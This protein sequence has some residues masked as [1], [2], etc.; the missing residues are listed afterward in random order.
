MSSFRFYPFASMKRI[1]FRTSRIRSKIKTLRS[2]LRPVITFP[3]PRICLCRSSTRCLL[4]VSLLKPQRLLP[5]HQKAFF[6]RRKRSND[7]NKSQHKP[8][9]HHLFS[10][11]L[12]FCSIRAS[13]TSMSLLSCV[14]QSCNKEGSNFL[15][16]GLKMTRF[17]L[18]SFKITSSNSLLYV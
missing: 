17:V 4:E 8:G 9:K 11:T 2:G 6:E 10:S 16:S 7:S 13:L 12:A 18:L 1:S 14:A 3:V 5:M 15:K